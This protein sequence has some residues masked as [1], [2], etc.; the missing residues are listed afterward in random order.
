MRET[1]YQ[2]MCPLHKGIGA[3][4][5]VYASGIPSST[6][7][8]MNCL[9]LKIT[10]HVIRGNQMKLERSRVKEKH[11]WMAERGAGRRASRTEK[12]ESDHK[13]NWKNLPCQP[14]WETP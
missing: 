12:Y 8:K 5:G 4:W 6:A 13:N 7:C 1:G 3:N 2:H 10:V 9:V 11:R 14:T